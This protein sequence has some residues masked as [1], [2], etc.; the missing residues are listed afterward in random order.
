MFKKLNIQPD[1]NV[2]IVALA[3]FMQMS[4]MG[5]VGPLLPLYIQDLGNYTPGEAAGWTGAIQGITF[6]MGAIFSPI[7]GNLGDRFG[8]KAMVLRAF[9]GMSVT[10]ALISF[11]PTPAWIFV[12]RMAH[13]CLGGAISASIAL[14]SS[15]TSEKRMGST[16]AF[17]H[18][19]ILAGNVGGPLL[20]GILADAFGF[21]VCF[22]L[23]SCIL[24]LCAVLILC[25]VNE[26]FTR[27]A[28]GA[29]Y[30]I[31]DNFRYFFAIKQLPIIAFVFLLVQMGQNGLNPVLPLFITQIYHSKVMVST[32]VGSVFAIT[33]IS[34]AMGATF[35][36]HRAD[37]KGFRSTLLITVA[38]ATLFFLV[39]PLTGQ[40]WQVYMV[41]VA[42]GL[43]AAGIVPMLQSLIAL[44]TATARRGS[45][46][47]TVMISHW[48]GN[49]IGP[50]CTGYMAAAVGFR[51][52]LAFS[53]ILFLAALVV[54]AIGIE[55]KRAESVKVSSIDS[56]DN[57][58]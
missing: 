10:M 58:A 21:K 45:M 40:L 51:M 34:A 30:S 55:E 4:G 39:L 19:A 6:L 12:I 46:V 15:F 43:F 50:V 47:G 32:V 14:V 22:L 23:T 7:W 11:A 56:I 9:F 37:A 27:P 2:I 16:L 3:L 5:L 25:L 41:R 8:R 33:G 1:R 42:T 31:R 29:T 17:L 35:W 49:A 44:N 38:G 36:G 18:T 24:V 57:E 26:Q 20:G 53:G 48:L 28:K 52:S 13:G 54:V